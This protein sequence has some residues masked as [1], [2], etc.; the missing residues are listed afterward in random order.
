ME[1]NVIK[2]VKIA[3]SPETAEPQDVE[4][5]Q[6]PPEEV[7]D[8]PEDETQDIPDSTPDDKEENPDGELPNEPIDPNEVLRKH[9]GMTIDEFED[10]KK[11]YEQLKDRP[12]VEDPELIPDD[13]FTKDLIR[14]Y[15]RGGKDAFLNYLKAQTTDFGSMS[16]EEIV[17]YELRQKHPDMKGK[18]F[19]R[20]YQDYL[21]KEFGFQDEYENDED[22]EYASERLRLHA[23]Q[24][25]QRFSEELKKFQ[26][27]DRQA[28]QGNEPDP[29]IEKTVQEFVRAV[30]TD[31]ATKSV[32]T[33][34]KVTFDD[35]NYQVDPDSLKAAALD[36]SNLFKLF[37][38]DDGSMDLDKFYKVVAIAKDPNAFLKA[39][40]AHIVAKAKV[41]FLR[42]IKNPSEDPKPKPPTGQVKVRSV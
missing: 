24:Q 37:F 26:V 23:Q 22:Q 6:T 20:M 13:D 3:P 15:K 12:Y 1:E 42:E 34:K 32:I 31:P 39:R 35:F 11:K 2:S 5:S 10:V 9:I 8:T 27:P 41:E 33:D 25:R 30:E 21:R 19:D 40:D 29:E 18:F 7:S 14:S 16:D 38:N 28:S 4:T 36:G 17:K